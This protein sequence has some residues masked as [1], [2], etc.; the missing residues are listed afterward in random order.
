M[1]T[2]RAVA[3]AL[4]S[5]GRIKTFCDQIGQYDPSCSCGACQKKL[6]AE[7]RHW[8]FYGYDDAQRAANTASTP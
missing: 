4:V 5:T 6:A 7:E 8:Y 1:R 3:N 2:R